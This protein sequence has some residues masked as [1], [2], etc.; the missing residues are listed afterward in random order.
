MFVTTLLAFLFATTSPS[1]NVIVDSRQTFQEAIAGTTAPDSILRTLTLVDV[2]Y[3]SF[4]RRLHRG[5]IVVH[6]ELAEDVRRIFRKIEAL[7]FPVESVIP[8]R[9]D[10]PDNGTSMDTLNNTYGFHYRPKATFRT[11]RLSAHAYGRAVDINPFRNPAILRSGQR[12]PAAG[13]YDPRQPGTL[14]AVSPLVR[15]FRQLGWRWGGSWASVKDYMH[16]EKP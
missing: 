10:K 12:I 1:D 2:E 13:R 16:F 4:D 5:Q 9:F 15:I 3:Y 14:T 8:I 6:K 7:R 11:A